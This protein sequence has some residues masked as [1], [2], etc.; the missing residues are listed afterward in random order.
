MNIISRRLNVFVT[1]IVSAYERCL[2][3][4]ELV[5]YTRNILS[6]SV[7]AKYMLLYHPRCV[8]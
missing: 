1:S 7:I 3:I 2:M 5:R 6:S 8:I 4:A